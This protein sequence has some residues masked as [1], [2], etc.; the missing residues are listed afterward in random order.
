MK[1]ENTAYKER[2][3]IQ[4]GMT[5]DHTSLPDK[6]LFFA[7]PHFLFFDGRTTLHTLASRTSQRYNQSFV[8]EC[9][10]SDPPFKDINYIRILI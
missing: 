1:I 5:A 2:T 7:D 9:N 10:L 6:V 8:K 4:N 3:E